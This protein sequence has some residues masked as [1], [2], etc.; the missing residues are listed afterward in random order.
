MEWNTKKFTAFQ[1]PSIPRCLCL[2]NVK[3]RATCFTPWN[4]IKSIT[5]KIT[6]I[7]QKNNN[8]S[9]GSLLD[10]EI[11][12]HFGQLPFH[13]L[14]PRGY[15]LLLRSI[16]YSFITVYVFKQEVTW[17]CRGCPICN[18]S[19]EEMCF[20]K[21]ELVLHDDTFGAKNSLCLPPFLERAI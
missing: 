5:Q 16:F 12:L 8:W 21:I 19:P 4:K 15:Q 1:F 10:T 13:Y 14:A 9:Y 17:P 20:S 6:E 11:L 3:I 2:W 18:L 7:L